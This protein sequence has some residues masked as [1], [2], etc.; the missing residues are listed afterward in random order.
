MLQPGWMLRYVPPIVHEE[1]ADL[2]RVF[3]Y[4]WAGLMFFTAAANLAL[5]LGDP[6]L[7]LRFL[8][9]FP[10]TSKL[11][12]FGIQYATMR[13]IIIQRRRRAAQAAPVAA[14]AEAQPA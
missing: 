4:V 6:K 14:S 5:A 8:A 2:I 7:W 9:V 3:G 1:A 10:A 13:V 12:L 11:V